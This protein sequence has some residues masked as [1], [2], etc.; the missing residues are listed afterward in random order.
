MSE[1]GN[2]EAPLISVVIPTYNRAELIGE[3]VGSAL[4]QEGVFALEIL[5]VDDGSTDETAQILKERADPR[6]RVIRMEHRGACAARNTGIREAKGEYI[7]FLD[8]DDLWHPD[9]LAAQLKQIRE[10][11]ADAVACAMNRKVEETGEESISPDQTTQD[12]PVDYHSL[13]KRNLISTQTLFGKTECF[14]EVLFDE[15]FPRMQDWD[16]V[17]RLAKKYRVWYYRNVLVDARVQADS[18]SRKPELAEKALKMLLWKNR[19]DYFASEEMLNGMLDEIAIYSLEAKDKALLE[20]R[21][22]LA[23][24]LTAVGAEAEHYRNR[25]RMVTHPLYGLKR[26]I[27]KLTGK[28]KGSGT[29]RNRQEKDRT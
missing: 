3:A 7:A 27:G 16:F 8:S 18:I 10:T 11:D 17:I 5:V 15:R 26:A 20:E 23:G 1:A 12:G 6:M 19:E 24:E 21:D 29:D 4:K 14:R 25:W 22:R 13:L 2:R 9:K 28:T